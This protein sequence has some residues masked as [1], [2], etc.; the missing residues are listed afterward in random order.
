MQRMQDADDEDQGGKKKRKP[1]LKKP[2]T[3]SCPILV[4]TEPSTSSQQI[5]LNVAA[6]TGT[7]KGIL[8]SHLNTTERV[9]TQLKKTVRFA[10]S[11]VSETSEKLNVHTDESCEVKTVI[12]QDAASEVHPSPPKPNTR[13]AKAGGD[14]EMS[15][16]SPKTR[17]VKGVTGVEES[18]ADAEMK[19]ISP[20][21]KVPTPAEAA[22]AAADVEMPSPK[23]RRMTA[24]IA[25]AAEAGSILPK[26]TAEA[27]EVG[28]TSPKSQ[29][30]KRRKAPAKST[31]GRNVARFR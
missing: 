4:D 8:S 3:R 5:T 10:S 26:I 20:K 12:C 31:A 25:A 6:E 21:R 23:T 15:T 2:L 29:K 11:S 19:T 27:E 30:M 17:R 16:P 18:A 28:A 13:R 14:V 24:A 1:K 9:E 7:R 22:V